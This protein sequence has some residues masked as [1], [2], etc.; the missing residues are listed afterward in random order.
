MI[1]LVCSQNIFLW[2]RFRNPVSNRKLTPFY[3]LDFSGGSGFLFSH[4]KERNEED[5]KARIL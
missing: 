1:L 5:K 3:F 2:K 4:V